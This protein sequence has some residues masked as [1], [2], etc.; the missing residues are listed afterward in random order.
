MASHGHG[1]SLKVVLWAIPLVVTGVLPPLEVIAM[2]VSSIVPS[3]WCS[4]PVD[5]HRD[6]CVVHPSRGVGRVVLGRALS[7][8]VRVI[9]LGSLLLRGEGPEVSI[10][11]KDV[12]EEYFRSDAC[13]GFLSVFLVCD[14]CRVA[15]DVFS[16]IAW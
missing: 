5:I 4:V 12:S 15:H 1:V 14:R 11:S 9:P 16:H 8:R 13:E 10:S 7:L 2:V 6:R 3:G